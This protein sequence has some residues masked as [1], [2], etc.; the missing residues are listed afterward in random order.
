[1][2]TAILTLKALK[3][4]NRPLKLDEIAQEIGL[5][6]SSAHRYMSMLTH[7]R[8]IEHSPNKQGFNVGEKALDY[9]IAWGLEEKGA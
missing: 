3:A 2:K 4:A 1:M 6:K 7:V 9:L 5:S 8:I